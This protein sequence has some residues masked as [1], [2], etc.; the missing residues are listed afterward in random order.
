MA[1]RV[2]RVIA[3]L[4]GGAAVGIAAA[5]SLDAQSTAST[6]GHNGD[7]PSGFFEEPAPSEASSIEAAASQSG[8]PSGFFD[9]PA[10]GE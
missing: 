7:L 10:P 8:M 3:V 9:Y 5:A 6:N 4:A 2:S 1:S